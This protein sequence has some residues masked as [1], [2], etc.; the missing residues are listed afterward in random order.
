MAA[1]AVVGAAA[2]AMGLP[3]PASPLTGGSAGGAAFWSL[4]S[5]E[6][7][8]GLVLTGGPAAMTAAGP[9]VFESGSVPPKGLRA[10]MA[11]S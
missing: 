9:G 1:A 6:G 11:D 4:G 2:R 5:A 8:T 3:K 10:G 7:P